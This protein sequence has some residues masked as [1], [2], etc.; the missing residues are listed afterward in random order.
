[1]RTRPFAIAV[2]VLTAAGFLAGVAALAP[3]ILTAQ[4]RERD[5]A[6]APRMG[7]AAPVS[8]EVAGARDIGVTVYNENLGVVR[9]VRRFDVRSGVSELRVTDVASTLEPTSVH[10]RPV[11]A[12]GFDVLW[13]DYRFD[14]VHTDRL[15]ERYLD[16]PV[17]VSMKDDQ[18][19]RGTLLSFDPQSIVLREGSGTILVLNRTEMEQI[20]LKEPPQGLVTRPTLVS[21]IRADRSGEQRVEVSYL[22]NAMSWRADYVAMVNDAG[23]QLDLQ[24]WASIENRSGA[25]Y[26]NAK[27]TLVA[28]QI[29]RAAPPSVPLPYA[30]RDMAMAQE[31]MA[32]GKAANEMVAR[33]FSE[34]HVYDVPQ[35]ITLANNE[36]KQMGL[37]EAANV[38]SARKYLYDGQRSEREVFTTLEFA[39]A[40]SGLGRPLPEGVVRVY[41]RDQDG[42]LRLTG[43]D[44]VRHTPANDTV[45]VAVG[46]AFDITA[47][48]SQSD[49][50][51]VNPRVVEQAF[52]IKLTNQKREAVDVT[53]VEHAWGSWE[54]VESSHKWRKKDANTLEFT[55]RC[56]PQRTVSVTYRLRITQ[57]G[58]G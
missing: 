7:E 56:P 28:G 31:G 24:A 14:L 30:T 17:E 10:L 9:D 5:A 46:A 15:L 40:G 45:R 57:P 50:R 49:Y 32:T 25:S 6:S 22:A 51:Q 41:Q 1:M 53:V 36:V 4:P 42:T 11:G 26:E 38:R 29:Q 44:R 8:P 37:L 16:Q 48:R 33:G 43:E 34:Y 27:L 35:R 54:V 3:T 2:A 55:V 58:R 18:V 13:Q 39:N 47:E 12:P 52:E 19:K 20:A 21:R 23:T